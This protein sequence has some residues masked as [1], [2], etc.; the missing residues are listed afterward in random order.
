M[1]PWS[2]T[3]SSA[4]AGEQMQK[5]IPQAIAGPKWADIS[6]SALERK[7][8][9]IRRAWTRAERKIVI[10]GFLRRLTIAIEPV[11]CGAVFAALTF[12]VI[13]RGLWFLTP[14][15]GMAVVAF[16]IYAL[17]MLVAPT[18][19]LVKTF[20][21][22][23]IVDGYVRYRQPDTESEKGANGYVAVLIHDKRLCYEWPSYGDKPLP[24]GTFP[25]LVEFSEFRGIHT[26]DG[27]STGIRPKTS[28]P[29]RRASRPQ[30]C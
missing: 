4:D 11:V 12:G 13:A 24:L 10:Q 28:A 19:A 22:I 18:R 7:H 27:R 29:A 6:L 17:V 30:S 23:Y 5:R 9:L 16:A 3:E 20:E 2:F 26:I 25:A 14:I 8:T 15:F 1:T 21:P